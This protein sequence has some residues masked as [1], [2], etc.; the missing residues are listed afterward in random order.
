MPLVGFDLEVLADELYSYLITVKSEHG[1]CGSWIVDPENGNLYG[2]V[3]AG[4]PKTGMAYI[5]SARAILEDIKL[6][7]GQ[8]IRLSKPKDVSTE[9]SFK[10]PYPQ[11]PSLIHANEKALCQELPNAQPATEIPADSK[12]DQP[13]SVPIISLRS[14]IAQTSALDASSKYPSEWGDDSALGTPVA[15][16]SDHESY[17]QL[18]L[19]RYPPEPN[20]SYEKTDKPRKWVDDTALGTSVASVSGYKSYQQLPLKRSLPEPDNLDGKALMKTH[21]PNPPAVMPEKLGFLWSVDSIEI[22]DDEKHLPRLRSVGSIKGNDI[23][24]FWFPPNRAKMFKRRPGNLYRWR[25]GESQR[26]EN[27]TRPDKK[28]AVTSLF[29]Q[30][31]QNNFVAINKDCTRCDVAEETFGWSYIGF[32]HYSGNLSEVVIGGE[33]SEL[34]APADG[35]S[36]M[37]QVLPHVYNYDA[38]SP[39]AKP[40]PGA[41]GGLCGSLS[42]LIGMAAFSAPENYAEDIV[43]RCFGFR[44]WKNHTYKIGIGRTYY[45]SLMKVSPNIQLTSG[46]LRRA[47]RPCIHLPRPRSRGYHGKP[48]QSI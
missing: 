45:L 9:E 17:H 14:Y 27:Y 43:S 30:A 7:T 40:P 36:W 4:Y 11:N 48:P 41:S 19:L 3:V 25:M 16:V 1:D 47:R 28:F 2:H 5:I 37:P 23:A 39:R 22:V 18:P 32:E 46:R 44:Q 42:L 13:E 29:F 34:A 21:K 8:D 6:Q 24:N 15:S 10:M 20:Y 33:K 12:P 38:K 26:L 35:S 31:K